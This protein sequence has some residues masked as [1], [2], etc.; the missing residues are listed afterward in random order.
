MPRPTQRRDDVVC[1]IRQPVAFTSEE[2]GQLKRQAYECNLTLT[3]LI[4][5][6]SLRCRISK[7]TA[8]PQL[9]EQL[10]KDLSSLGISLN[11]IVKRV[12]LAISI[13]SNPSL[14]SC[15]LNQLFA[16]LSTILESI[17]SQ[18]ATVERKTLAI[19][20]RRLSTNNTPRERRLSVRLAPDEY[21]SLK[22]K[23]SSGRI[24]IAQLLRRAALRLS[25]AEPPPPP[26]S[27]WKIHGELSRITNNLRQLLRAVNIAEME[28]EFPHETVFQALIQIQSVGLQLLGANDEEAQGA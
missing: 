5:F 23:A 2:Y 20:S 25:I 9:D 22:Q 26:L 12:N 10:H 4:R 17:Q 16:R 3:E 21:E 13:D 15:Q 1:N 19:E 24:S 14:H 7:P 6:R 28:I 27:Y 11:Q 8:Y 18:L